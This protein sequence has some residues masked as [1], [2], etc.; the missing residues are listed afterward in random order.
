M[1]FYSFSYGFKQSE[2]VA[3]FANSAIVLEQVAKVILGESRFLDN[4]S[5]IT[6][7]SAQIHKLISSVIPSKINYSS[8]Q[9]S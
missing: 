1:N 9:N 7:I 6:D 4:T 2:S 3:P 5:P 8:L